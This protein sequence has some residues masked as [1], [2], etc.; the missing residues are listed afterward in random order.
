MPKQ[1]NYVALAAGILS[2]VLIAVS[3]FVPWWQFKVGNPVL[4]TVNFSPVNFNFSFFNTL[5]TVPLIWALNIASLLTLLAGGIALLIYS[6]FPTKSYAKPLLGFG[7]KK[8]LYAVILFII[9]LVVLFSSAIVLTGVSFPLVGSSALKLPSSIAPGGLSISVDISAAFGWTFYL[10]LVVAALC[11]AARI[12]HRKVEKL[13]SAKPDH[14]A[15][16][17][18]PLAPPPPTA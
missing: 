1:R 8:P 5:L 9:E 6:A 18:N 4:A 14:E 16:T 12:Y 7:Y 3:F 15:N 13:T 10:A 2:L 17:A 11:I